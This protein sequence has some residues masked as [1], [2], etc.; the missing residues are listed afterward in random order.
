MPSDEEAKTDVEKIREMIRLL[1]R[2]LDNCNKLLAHVEA[3]EQISG[4]DNE[5]NVKRPSA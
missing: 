2:A 4:Q 1:N 5:P 3:P